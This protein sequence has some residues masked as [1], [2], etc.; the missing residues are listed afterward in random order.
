MVDSCDL[1]SLRSAL[2]I[3]ILHFDFSAEIILHYI[4]MVFLCK[5][6]PR[7]TARHHAL[8]NVISGAFSSAGMPRKNQSAS[9]ALTEKGLTVLLQ[10][11]HSI[12][13]NTSITNDRLSG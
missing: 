4:Y 10:S 12:L 9:L 1:H 13:T 11:P 6:A 3:H 5:S 7:R 2:L 8:N